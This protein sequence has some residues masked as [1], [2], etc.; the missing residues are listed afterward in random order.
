MG[1]L[2]K[3]A[4]W[5]WRTFQMSFWRDMQISQHPYC[6]AHTTK[7]IGD[8]QF[9]S[10]KRGENLSPFTNTFNPLHKGKGLL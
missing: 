6:T 8:L 4:V 1:R 9:H 3:G 2:R 5:S 7:L 10:K